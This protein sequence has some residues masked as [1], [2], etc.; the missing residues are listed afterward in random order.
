MGEAVI[1]SAVRTAIADARRG[2][3]ARTPIQQIAR[4]SV[5]EAIKRSGA[6]LEDIDDVVLGEVMHGGGCIARYVALDLGL[7]PDTPGLAVQRH[8]ASGLQGVLSAAADIRSGMTRLAVAGGAES[9]SQTPRTYLA[10]PEPFGGIEPWMSLTHPLTPDAPLVMGITVGENTATEAGIT[11]E[12]QD[13][14]AYN[15][16]ARALAAIDDGRFAE[17][18]TAIEV[19]DR[20]GVV[21]VFDRDEHPRRDTSPE[22]LAALPPLFREGGTVTAGNSSSFNDGSAALVV[23]DS[24]YA[25]ERELAPLAVIRSWAAAGIEPARTGLAPTLA[26]PKALARAG[27]SPEDISLVEINEAFASMAVACARRLGFPPERVNVNGGAVGLG[28]PVA[29]SGARILVTLVHELRRRGGG[30]GVA[31]LCAGGGMAVA[32]VVEVLAP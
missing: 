23:A 24:R 6:P 15:S 30:Y 29:A 19:T 21:S 22:R 11:R 12:D 10:S 28:H 32:T 18:V 9:M 27:L 3:L 5:A 4:A 2:A 17:E 20:R 14:W 8:C 13:E 1:L 31:T 26:V 16:H 7:P 25:E